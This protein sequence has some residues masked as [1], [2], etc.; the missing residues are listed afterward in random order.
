MTKKEIRKKIKAFKNAGLLEEFSKKE[1]EC[2]AV[3]YYRID[4]FNRLKFTEDEKF[5][6]FVNYYKKIMP[7]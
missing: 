5:L 7:L 1:L 6:F 2:L 3:L 4:L